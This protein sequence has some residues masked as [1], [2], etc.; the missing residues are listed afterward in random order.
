MYSTIAKT[1]AAYFAKINAPR[2]ETSFYMLGWTPGTY[3]TLDALKANPKVK[4]TVGDA[5]KI[6]NHAL[7]YEPARLEV[8]PPPNMLDMPPPLPRCSSTS[9]VSR[10]V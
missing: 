9:R 10:S 3:D 7:V 1:E 2:Y 8:T 6:Q 5:C 4:V